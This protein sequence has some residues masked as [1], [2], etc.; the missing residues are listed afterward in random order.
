LKELA[1]KRVN[2]GNAGLT[3]LWNQN[4]D[5][6]EA[7]RARDRDFLPSLQNYFEEAIEQLDPANGIE[8]EYKKVNNGEWGWRALRLMSRRSSHFFISGNNPIA[9]LPEYLE[10]MLGKMA[11]EMP[12]INSK[13][14]VLGSQD[15]EMN[16]DEVGDAIPEAAGGAEAGDKADSAAGVLTDAQCAELA[17]KLAGHWR[18]L[19][20]KLGLA[21]E[22]V[23][24]MEAEVDG[25]ED[26]CALVFAAW[27]DQEG[28]GATREEI[29]YV[30]EGLKLSSKIEGLF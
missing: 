1:E 29:N 11:K 23:A 7:C 14:E 10:T 15:E 21:E 17:S 16:M 18:K 25:E 4:P 9:K 28:E 22:K 3:A 26:R 2:L 27:K 20:P 8:D 5:N 13:Q 24:A 6:L 12:G 30:L 19:A